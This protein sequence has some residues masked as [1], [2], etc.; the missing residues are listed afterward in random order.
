MKGEN[1][2]G[3]YLIQIGYVGGKAY[4]GTL[5]TTCNNVSYANKL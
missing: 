1:V 5:R 4:T 2:F 3:I